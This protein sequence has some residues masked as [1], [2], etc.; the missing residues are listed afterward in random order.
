MQSNDIQIPQINSLKKCLRENHKDINHQF[1]NVYK[2]LKKKLTL[3]AKK[4]SCSIINGWIKSICNH[5][6]WCCRSCDGDEQSVREKW[7]SI[8]FNIQNKHFWTGN[9]LFLKC[10]HP[11]IPQ[12]CEKSWS[13]PFSEAFVALQNIILDKSL[14]SDLKH[15]INFSH[16]GS[17]EV[18]HSS[19]NRW[20][21]ESTHFSY[22]GMI[23]FS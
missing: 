13:N 2:N 12:D 3:S 7:F 10:C 22:Q 18:Y 8:L 6:W 16:R 9:M 11:N 19:Y 23:A 20:L 21:L 15:L 1:D 5:F 14:L 17:L 4:K